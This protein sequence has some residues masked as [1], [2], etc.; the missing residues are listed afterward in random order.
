MAEGVS[1]YPRSLLMVLC[2]AL[3]LSLA[4]FDSDSSSARRKKLSVSLPGRIWV[5]N[6]NVREQGPPDSHR[7]G[8]MKRFVNKALEM[9]LGK[10][11]D[12]VLLQQLNASS[13]DW[14]AGEFSRITGRTFRVLLSPADSVRS[15]GPKMS[16]RDDSAILINSGTMRT[17]DSG[18]FAVSQRPRSAKRIATQQAVPWAEL[19]ERGKSPDRLRTAVTSIHFPTHRSFKGRRTSHR[20]KARWSRK[21]H[22]LLAARMPDQGVGDNRVPILAGDFN[23]RMCELPTSYRRR[24]CHPTKFNKVLTEFNYREAFHVGDFPYRDTGFI[25]FIFTRG[26]IVDMARD[27]EFHDHPNLYSDHPV[28]AALIEDEDSTGPRRADRPRVQRLFGHL[29]VQGWGY[30]MAGWDGGTGFRR[31]LLYRR[32]EESVSW[33]L[34]ARLSHAIY[35]DLEVDASEGEAFYYRV[36]GEDWAGNLSKPS[37]QGNVSRNPQ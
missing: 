13:A 37:R 1:R 21:L 36:I 33:E 26:N 29:I 25:D 4:V 22:R 23:A 9:T 16:R 28:M 15:N 34:I 5:V 8:D 2:A 27:Y 18:K 17:V 35:R 31:W 7:R 14:L 10:A 6:G 32:T 11:P 24:N 20:H 3:T 19:I 12:V 30:D